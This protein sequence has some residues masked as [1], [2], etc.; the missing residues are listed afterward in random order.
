MTILLPVLN[1]PPSA[2]NGK[3]RNSVKLKRTR[4]PARNPIAV[5]GSTGQPLRVG[6]HA[7]NKAIEALKKGKGRR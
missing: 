7:Y 6:G 5:Y 3:K 4:R 2:R 1:P